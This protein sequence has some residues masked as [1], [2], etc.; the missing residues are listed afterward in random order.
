MHR[1]QGLCYILLALVAASAGSSFSSRKLSS[2]RA[3]ISIPT[4]RG[5]DQP[6]KRKKKHKSK[7]KSKRIKSSSEISKSIGDDPAKMMGDAIR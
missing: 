2:S 1:I 4:V 7:S 5:G 3:S 6:K